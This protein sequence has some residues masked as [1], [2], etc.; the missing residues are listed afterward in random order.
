MKNSVKI[1]N[2]SGICFIFGDDTTSFQEEVDQLAEEE[3]EE[4]ETLQ[5]TV[6][7]P[8]FSSPEE[9]WVD[10]RRLGK[11]NKTNNIAIVPT[12]FSENEMEKPPTEML[13]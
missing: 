1:E 13:N 7:G 4:I 8:P 3:E 9:A 5:V 12:T 2:W 6:I 10:A 11:E